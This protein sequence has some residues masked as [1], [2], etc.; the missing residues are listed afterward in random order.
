MSDRR[1]GRASRMGWMTSPRQHDVGRTY[2]S[3]SC[4]LIRC[5]TWAPLIS[6]RKA[7][8][9]T[10]QETNTNSFED[11]DGLW[12]HSSGHWTRERARSLSFSPRTG[13]HLSSRRVQL[14]LHV[15]PT[16]QLRGGAKDVMPRTTTGPCDGASDVYEKRSES[17]ATHGFMDPWQSLELISVQSSRPQVMSSQ[18]ESCRAKLSPDQAKPSQTKPKPSSKSGSCQARVK[19][20]SKLL[21]RP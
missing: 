15:L 2:P 12:T 17:K 6:E 9:V 16:L 1:L 10:P 7:T 14:A 5:T 20:R 13:A 19:L 21:R 8:D 18:V 4:H 11:D 3:L